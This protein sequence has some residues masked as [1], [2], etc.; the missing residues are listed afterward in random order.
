MSGILIDL[1]LFYRFGSVPAQMKAFLDSTSGLWANGGLA[2]KLTSVFVSTGSNHGGQEVSPKKKI[3]PTYTH[4]HL[5]LAL[6]LSLYFFS[7]LYSTLS[8]TLR[9]RKDLS[10]FTTG[11]VN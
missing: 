10:I 2:G 3:K 9:V 8:P 7:P 4:P 5:A 6:S 11:L 1:V